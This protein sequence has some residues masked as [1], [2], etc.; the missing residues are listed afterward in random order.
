MAHFPP[1]IIQQNPLLRQAAGPHIAAGQNARTGRNDRKA[2]VLQCA[3]IVLC[4]GILQ[5]MGVHGGSHQ[6]GTGGGQRHG[7]EHIVR[8]AVGHLGDDVC[9]G[10]GHQNQVG[11]VGQRHMSH[12]IL[13]VPVKGIHNA[14][15]VGQRFKHQR[16]DELGGVAGHQHMNI[17]AGLCQRVGHIGHLVGRNPSGDAKDDGFALQIHRGTSF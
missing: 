17:R 14:A 13:E 4:D 6:L 15:V 12:I 8:N 2:V 1:A 16:C 10:R 3:Q 7:G 11:G 5:H 9:R